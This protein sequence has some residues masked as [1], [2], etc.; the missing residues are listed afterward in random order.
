MGLLPVRIGHY[1][2]ERV[3][4]LIVDKN[5]ILVQSLFRIFFFFKDEQSSR[6]RLFTECFQLPGDEHVL[7]YP[8]TE[9]NAYPGE[10]PLLKVRHKVFWFLCLPLSLLVFHVILTTAALPPRSHRSD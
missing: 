10:A 5:D 3:P 1:G 9:D 7:Q 2:Y 4:D 8:L 6:M